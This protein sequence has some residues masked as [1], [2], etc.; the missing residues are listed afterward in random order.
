MENMVN[1]PMETVV[2]TSRIVSA[3]EQRCLSPGSDITRRSFLS[4]GVAALA[5]CAA[6]PKKSACADSVP[7]FMKAVMLK[8]GGNNMADDRWLHDDWPESKKAKMRVAYTKLHFDEAIWREATERMAQKG[9]N[10]VLI[11]LHE[12]VEYPR[13]PELAVEGSW[14]PDKLRDELRRLRG[15]GIL[16]VPKLNFSTTHSAWQKKWRYRTSSPEYYRFCEDMIADVCEI[17]DTPPLFHIGMDEEVPIGMSS[18]PLMI[19]RQGDLWWHDFL[20]LVREVERR[21][22]RCWVWSDK[23]WRWENDGDY[24]RRCP[25]SV[26]QSNWF[27]LADFSLWRRKFDPKVIAKGGWGF[28]QYGPAGYLELEKAGF[29]QVPTGSNWYNDAN[30][31]A[32]VDFCREHIS[33]AHLKGFMSASWMRCIPEQRERLLASID[34]LS[35]ALRR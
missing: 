9:L 13:H 28:H 6:M 34:Q 11:D 10:V 12:G 25:R 23:L 24:L 32:T 26:L 1:Q 35:A 5:G 18:S 3:C 20:F 19:V 27:Y 2:K 8:L 14:S 29:D 7:D 15:M 31:G 21:G 4:S 30:M 22:V 16:P 17:F 33:H